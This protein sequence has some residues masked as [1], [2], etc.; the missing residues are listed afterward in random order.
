MQRD[1]VERCASALDGVVPGEACVAYIETADGNGCYVIRMSPG[2]ETIWHEHRGVEDF[3]IL[4]GELIECDGTV[5]GPGDFVSYR[6]GTQHNSRSDSGCLLIGFDW[7][8]P[9]KE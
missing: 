5:L 2:A 3:L 4:E 7:G 6:P 1:L 8:K 9:A